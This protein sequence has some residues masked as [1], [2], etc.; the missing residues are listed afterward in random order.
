[1]ASDTAPLSSR[2]ATGL[3][4]RFGKVLLVA[5]GVIVGG[6]TVIPPEPAAAVAAPNDPIESTI[7]GSAGHAIVRLYRAYFDRVPDEAGLR[8]WGEVYLKNQSLTRIGGWM[9][10]SPEFKARWE[11]V[12]DRDFIERL[13]YNNLLQREPDQPG[14]DYWS[15]II[16]KVPRERQAVYWVQQPEMVMMHPVVEPEMCRN[17]A[18]RDIPGGRVLDVDYLSSDLRTSSSRCA[19]AS[20]NANWV[21]PGGPHRGK[22]VGFAAIGGVEVSSLGGD[23][24]SR[25]IFGSRRIGEGGEVADFSHTFDQNIGP[26]N[27]LSNL[28]RKGDSMLQLHANYWDENPS[29]PWYD[30]DKFDGKEQG[31]DWAAGGISLVVNGQQNADM[32]NAYTFDTIRHSFVAFRAPSTVTFGSTVSMTAQQLVDYLVSDGYTDIMKMDGGGSVEFY[33]LGKSTVGGTDRDVP[34]WLGVGC[35]AP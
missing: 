29:T 14:L 13:L 34:V 11:G 7:C 16:A 6:F 35:P 10:D 21:V 19:V 20:I 30:A 1:V 12:G 32:S 15:G 4:T 31:W 23:D 24:N 28:T 17:A 5:L 9:S 3:R 8:Y 27:I 22:V 18:V 26:I 33:E 2:S 25:G